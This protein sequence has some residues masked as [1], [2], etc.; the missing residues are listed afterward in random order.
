[1]WYF[2]SPTIVF[3]P[4]SL[5]FLENIKGNKIFIVTDPDLVKLKLVDIVTDKLKELSKQYMIFSEVEP[6]PHEDTIIKGA[7]KC[8]EY[9]PDLIIGFGGGSSM[10]TAKSIWAFYE[11]DRPDFGVD[12]FHP[13][14]DLNLGRKAKMI[15]IPTTAGTGAETTWAVVITRIKEDGTNIKLEQVNKEL[16]PTY[17]IVDPVFTKGLPPKLT[18][19]TG[20][21]AVAHILE[22]L[23]SSWKN[24]FSDALGIRAFDLIQK[25]LPRA[26][27]DGSDEEAREHMSNAATMAG[28]CFGN[29]QVIL[30]HSLGHVLGATFHVPHGLAVGL[31]LPYVLQYCLNDPENDE[32][33]EILGRASKMVGLADWSDSDGA[34]SK[35]L[36]QGVKDLQK[37]VDFPQAIKEIGISKE[38]FEAKLDFMGEMCL[39]SGAGVMSPRSADSTMYKKLYQYA[40]DGKDVDF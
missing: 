38:D 28:L 39:E 29:S 14:Q 4:D 22:G 21:D 40:Y 33:K 3:G 30:G 23:I 5:D 6:D 2:Y 25:Y 10:D 26:Y 31:F 19:A 24:D 32:A 7:E 11:N 36:I 37:Q 18:A 27:K 20:F 34:A 35:K 9:A 16:I 8:K 12:D 1:M 17:A 15:A 13:F